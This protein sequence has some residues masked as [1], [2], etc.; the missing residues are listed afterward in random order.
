MVA[1]KPSSIVG[2]PVVGPGGQ[3]ICSLSWIG[4][5]PD[6]VSEERFAAYRAE[7]EA[8]GRLIAAAPSMAEAL[9]PFAHARSNSGSQLTVAD[10]DRALAAFTAALTPTQPDELNPLAQGDS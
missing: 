2:W 1:A 7:V 8:N 6:D 10:F 9:R 3:S 5:K 4:T